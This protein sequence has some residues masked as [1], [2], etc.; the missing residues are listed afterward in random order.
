[1]TH[2]TDLNIKKIKNAIEYTQATIRDNKVHIGR[3][4]QS[5]AYLEQAHGLTKNMAEEASLEPMFFVHIEI[6]FLLN[7]IDGFIR[8]ARFEEDFRD[9]NQDPEPKEWANLPENIITTCKH[10][11]D[12]NYGILAKLKLVRELLDATQADSAN[13]AIN[14][15]TI[16]P[17]PTSL[18]KMEPSQQCVIDEKCE[19]DEKLT[20][21]NAFIKTDTFQ[22]L[23]RVE[24]LLLRRQLWVMQ[25]YSK[26]LE[27]RIKKF[28]ATNKHVKAIVKMASDFVSVR[29]QL[30]HEPV[31]LPDEF[32][33][34][35][36]KGGS[37]VAPT[38]YQV[39]L[40]VAEGGN[41]PA[42]FDD[43]P[44]GRRG[45][46]DLIAT[47][48]YQAGFDAGVMSVI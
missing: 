30:A 31:F 11:F 10:C 13:F 7:K 21:F 41:F 39:E 29:E 48:A 43:H 40:W 26:T 27:L 36:G 47:R 6:D 4:F 32:P 25:E 35:D 14:L 2:F 3:L 18:P 24:Q 38:R 1:M 9:G 45:K 15:T 20:R 46:S 44:H 34:K 5:Q 28:S 23:D 17:Y 37:P 8:I 16:N 42:S 33:F 22:G 12:K 19:L